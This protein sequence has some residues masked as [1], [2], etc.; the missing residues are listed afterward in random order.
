MRT[1]SRCRIERRMSDND[2]GSEAVTIGTAICACGPL[3]VSFSDSETRRGPSPV[4]DV[5]CLAPSSSQPMRSGRARR[6]PCCPCN[7][8]RDVRHSYRAGSV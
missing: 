5:T 2:A 4:G 3:I 8:S 6:M 7:H 1:R